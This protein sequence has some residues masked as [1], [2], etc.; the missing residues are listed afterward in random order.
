MMTVED[1][2][3]GLSLSGG[4]V[5]AAVFHLGVL[6][7]LADQDLLGK[8]TFI[9]TVSGGSLAAGL[10]HSRSNNQWPSNS[11][12]HCVVSDV[13]QLLTSINLER[14]FITGMLA[15]P[16]RLAVGG[17][18]VLARLLERKWDIHG[19]LRE[20]PTEPRWII[21]ATTYDTGKNW[22]FSQKRMGD[23]LTSYALTPDFPISMAVAASAAVPGLIGPLRMDAD[24]YTW[25]HV[26]ASGRPTGDQQPPISRRILLW[27]G[28]V[29]DNMGLEALL[30]VRGGFRNGVNFVI[31][32]DASR[33][34]TIDSS[35]VRL[36]RPF[37]IPPFRLIDIA[38][39]QSRALRSRILVQHFLNNPNTGVLVRSGNTHET[40]SRATGRDAVQTG[41][42]STDHANSL[43]NMKT[44]LRCLTR[45][46]FDCLALHGYE[47][48]DATLSLYCPALFRSCTCPPARFPAAP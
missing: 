24:A 35:R 39:D 1:L 47:A 43:M 36:S 46:E 30:K 16:W 29:Y 28:G 5:R 41:L 10:I 42:I 22:R 20:L 6:S 3:I 37:Y 38:T 40:V 31:A 34:L 21:N 33:P 44:T 13:R 32:S 15:R 27:D 48:A 26:D 18:S 14:L 12:F 9:S 25:H 19:S 2:Q 17:A 8:V 7:R 45:Q 11:T 4:G 23:Y